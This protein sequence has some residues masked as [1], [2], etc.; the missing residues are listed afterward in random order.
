MSKIIGIDL[1][2][3]NSCVAVMEGKDPVVIPNAEGKR[4]TPSIVAF[5]E[6]GERKVGDPAKRQA[7]T[8]P[9]NT[10]YS[11]KRFIGTH[12]KDDGSE[13][14]RVP[15]KV[16]SGPNDTVKVKIN[17]R[18][19]TPQEISA[20]ILQKMKKTAEDYLGQEVTRA[21]I[22]VPA[23]FND[24]QRQ[25][26]K[27]AGEI[28]GLKVERIINEPTAA[29]LAYGLDK[30]HK[31]QKIAVYDLGGGTFDISIL[32]LGD[33]V[34]EVLSTNGDTHLGGDDFD[35][36]IIN[37]MAEEFKAEEGVDLKADAIAL[38]RLKEAAEKAKIELSSSAQTE[39]NLPYITATA[40]G[41]KHLVKTLTKAKF[42]QLSADLVRRSMEPCKKALQDAGLSTSDIDEVILVG[43][44]TRI[45]IIQEEVEK[46]FGKKPSKG[47]NPDEV[48][49]VGAAIQGGVLTGDV[50]DV[51]LLD[52]TPLSLGIETMGSVFT[53][54][55]EA[56]TTI[57]TKKSEVFS[58]ASDNQPAVTIRVG[59]GERP[60]FNDN[61]EIGRFELTDIPPAPRGVPQIE[62]TF[63]IDANGI[64]SVS[65]KDKGTGKE[66][67]IKIQASS[68]LS[69]EEIEKMKKEAQEN[70]SADA[71]KKEEVEVFNKAD[72][73][74]FQT[75]KQLKE[76]GDKLSADKKAAIESA[77]AE[78]KTAFEAKDLEAV[79]TK[80]EALDAA[81][82]AASEEMYAQQGQANPQAGAQQNAGGADDVQ[83]ADFEEVR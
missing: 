17:D 21:V 35:D 9:T 73:L 81:W 56:N 39:I 48:V 28:A 74:I 77:A 61:K 59:Q 32:D 43:G 23:Y 72:G 76:F 3:T 75:E 38:Q 71:K 63:D 25:A 42:E 44:S 66:Q 60:M 70:A 53:K 52:V 62:V 82:M 5:T 36:V 1:G 58:T 27:E 50:K 47:V 30:N 14:A 80:T 34:F 15:Y 24:A 33:G 41:P 4:T 6:D 54:L 79:K 69:D 55:I 20:M 78:L 31:D 2:T 46:F 16:V 40:T 64:L 51:L 68:G 8:N 11:I 18:E 13:V 37:W 12:F 67:S 29:A 10:V 22:T 7:V 19:Y 26:T 49:A 45:P 57:P 65:A 83:D